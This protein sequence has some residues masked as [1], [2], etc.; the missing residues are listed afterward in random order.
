MF[1]S[2]S[3]SPNERHRIREACCV[4][5]YEAVW[6]TGYACCWRN[7]LELACKPLFPG[8]ELYFSPPPPTPSGLTWKARGNDVLSDAPEHI[9]VQPPCVKRLLL[10]VRLRLLHGQHWPG[11]TRK[12]TPTSIR[13][14]AW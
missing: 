8:R 7:L 14:N 4:S 2:P 10:G 3:I 6:P 1:I 12:S 11:R 5:A 13:S 9:T